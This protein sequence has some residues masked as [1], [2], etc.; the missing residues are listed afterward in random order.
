MGEMMTAT[1]D[2]G[3][4]LLSLPHR[5]RINTDLPPAVILDVDGTLIDARPTMHHIEKP[6]PDVHAFVRD[7]EHSPPMPEAVEFAVEYAQSGHHVIVLSAR[8]SNWHKLTTRQVRQHL[9][10]SVRVVGPIL[11]TFGD[12][13]H[14]AVYK[15]G[16]FLDLIREWNIVAAMDDH[17]G[18]LDLWRAVGIPDVREVS[19]TTYDDTHRQRSLREMLAAGILEQRDTEYG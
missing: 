15:Y 13:A 2:P 10:E 11:K 14:D 7:S 9:P 19:V 16:V 6:Q 3:S 17:P 18:V 4:M 12:T 1:L 8:A 5:A